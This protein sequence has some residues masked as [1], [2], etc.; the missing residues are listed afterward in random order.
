M[1][2]TATALAVML[3][4]P[5]IANDVSEE[6]T[7]VFDL[8]DVIVIRGGMPTAQQKSTTRYTLDRAKIREQGVE[9]LD[10]ALNSLPGV[11]V[12]TGPDGVPRVDMRGFRTRH[13]TLLINGVPANSSY[14]G[15][16]DPTLIPADRIERIEVAM[17]PSS[18]LY[19]P[20]GNAGVINVITKTGV[21]SQGISAELGM[22]NDGRKKAGLSVAG[23]GQNSDW[24]LAYTGYRQDA[25]TVPD[26]YDT[27]PYEDGGARENSDVKSDQLYTAANWQISGQTKIGLTAELGQAEKGKPGR[28]GA[29]TDST[30]RFE[31]VD[32]LDNAGIQLSLSHQ[33]SG[34]N[35]VRGF[36]YLNQ[37]DKLLQRYED[38]TY[39]VITR[40]TDS[41]SRNLGF[42]GQWLLESGDHLFTLGL[43]G[44]RQGYDADETRYSA[45]G[46]GSGSGSGGG[47]D[48]GS[49]SGG[50]SGS[51][52]GGGSGS[53]SGGGSGTSAAS[54]TRTAA[55]TTAGT[56]TTTSFDESQDLYNL[57]AEY[58]WQPSDNFGSSLGLGLHRSDVQGETEPSAT[59]S[60][61]QDLS[62]DLRLNAALARKIR[63]PSIRN[64]YEGSAANPNLDTEKTDH[65]EL[66]SRY[67]VTA[68][69]TLSAAI[70]RSD[71]ENYI[72][73]DTDGVYRNYAEYRFQGIDLLWQNRAL[74]ALALDLGYSYLDAVNVGEDDQNRDQ[75]QNRPEHM[76]KASLTARLPF[77]LSARLD[78][79]RI[80]GQVYYDNTGAVEIDDYNL[81]D[82]NL[83]QP[84]PV[85]GFSWQLNITNLTD[86]L[87]YQSQDLPAPGR[88]W[89]FSLKAEL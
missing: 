55:A 15:Q 9:T 10:Q 76:V 79:Q 87:Y 7:N 85:K 6:Q 8:Q 38:E 65:I 3:A 25:F 11:Y 69:D 30:V 63:F 18:L 60:V 72:E 45:S 23:R 37:H 78:A 50:G 86:E 35:G 74:D 73:K 68:K 88:Q 51:G 59:I 13:V 41:R 16:F 71:M 39:Q 48:S 81:F 46:S 32:D 20:G 33:L 56:G 26:D 53:G 34:N 29:L 19:G 64:L 84:L 2:L 31:R 40:S 77:E 70:Y 43:I 12:R 14:D 22:G 54:L 42:N 28:A 27:A 89:M 75:L 52:S 47:S 82:L 49:G 80:M 21:Q 1:R 57:V 36:V 44:E 61:Y 5:A 62:A 58:Q 66:G 17:G 83:M 24:L 4:T 67:F